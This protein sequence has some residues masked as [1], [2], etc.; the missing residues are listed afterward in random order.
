MAI[1]FT[2]INFNILSFAQE[3]E[4][5]IVKDTIPLESVSSNLNPY[6]YN[7][8]LKD[9]GYDMKK[10]K[11]VD[12]INENYNA[13]AK[14]DGNF[15]QITFSGTGATKKIEAQTTDWFIGTDLTRENMSK[16]FNTRFPIKK[17]V[18]VDKMSD[19]ND[20]KLTVNNYSFSQNKL[21]VDMTGHYIPHFWKR[22][23]FTKSNVSR[24]KNGYYRWRI[25]YTQTYYVENY[26]LYEGD[27]FYS[28]TH[29][30]KDKRKRGIV[31]VKGTEQYN[32]SNYKFIDV[33]S[34][35]YYFGSSGWESYT[36]F[37]G[38][39]NAK[40][41]RDRK[42]I[43]FKANSLADFGAELTLDRWEYGIKADYTYE[44]EG[45]S[46]EGD[47][48]VYYEKK[49]PKN[50]DGVLVEAVLDVPERVNINQEFIADATKSYASGDDWVIVNYQWFL[51]YPNEAELKEYKEFEGKDKI[52]VSSSVEGTMTIRVV[53]H[54]VKGSKKGTSTKTLNFKME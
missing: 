39:S 6:I 26:K 2:N 29:S 45:Y 19:F 3:Y 1:I 20:T 40:M 36:N 31:E 47:L 27:N 42:F 28:P 50:D 43:D 4:T 7:V 33:S 51:R 9:L 30:L 54:W 8:N 35:D 41:T 5:I 32:K 53:V 12:V 52:T 48:V 21:T 25:P 34:T 11:S 46:Y 18:S 37:Q 23:G 17:I 16:T 14:I 22:F 44:I 10:V 24:L 49:F 15:A 38:G 13:S